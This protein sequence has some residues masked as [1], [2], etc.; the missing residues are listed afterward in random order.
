MQEVTV[1]KPST[2][3][4]LFV[5]IGEVGSVCECFLLGFDRRSS[6][7]LGKLDCVVPFDVLPCI[8]ISPSFF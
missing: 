1:S 6:G 8:F 3:V 7:S 2:A 4:E 5:D